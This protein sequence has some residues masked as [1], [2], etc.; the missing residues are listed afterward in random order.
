MTTPKQPWTAPSCWLNSKACWR[1]HPPPILPAPNPFN[2]V[3]ILTRSIKTKAY[4][5]L[6]GSRANICSNTFT[7]I[8]NKQEDRLGDRD[9]GGTEQIHLC[10]IQSRIRSELHF[11]LKMWGAEGQ[12]TEKKVRRTTWEKVWKIKC[13][14]AKILA[15]AFNPHKSY[16]SQFE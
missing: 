15:P 6:E 9:G 1:C 3:L 13:E 8:K 11:V 12:M 16:L 5:R 7:A 10:R 2:V 14:Q 4:W